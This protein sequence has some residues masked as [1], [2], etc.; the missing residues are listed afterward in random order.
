MEKLKHVLARRWIEGYTRVCAIRWFP[1]WASWCGSIESRREIQVTRR[2][3][4][5]YCPFAVLA[6]QDSFFVGIN[7]EDLPVSSPPFCSLL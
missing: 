3:I 1:R 6:K 7:C 2:R 4:I 5:V